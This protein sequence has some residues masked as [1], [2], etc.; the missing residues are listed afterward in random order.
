MSLP[1]GGSS[2]GI[3]WFWGVVLSVAFHLLV[4]LFVMF[5]GFGS[6]KYSAQPN[7]IEGTLVSL[8]D[9]ADTEGNNEIKASQVKEEAQKDP[10]REEKK[11]SGGAKG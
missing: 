5:W 9:L 7:F 11:A 3:N 6:S 8:S 1:N 10:K 4:F 2:G